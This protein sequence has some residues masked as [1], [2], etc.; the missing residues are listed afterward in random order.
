MT[1]DEAILNNLNQQIELMV[2]ILKCE[3]LYLETIDN[4]TDLDRFIMI[5]IKDKFE[6]VDKSNYFE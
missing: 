5:T 1:L 6:E 2:K 3:Q 4:P